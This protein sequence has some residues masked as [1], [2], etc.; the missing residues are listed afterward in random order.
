M[1]QSPA[2]TGVTTRSQTGNYYR[3]VEPDSDITVCLKLETVERLQREALHGVNGLAK[4]RNEVGGILLG[5]VE[6]DEGRTLTFVDDFEAVPCEYRSGASYAL[7][8]EAGAFEAALA[9]HGARPT[10]SVVGYYRSH[11]RE[12][13]YLSADD[14]RLIHRHFRGP[15][16]LFLLIKTLPNRA[17]TAGFFFWKD[18]RIQSEFTDSEAPLIPI[19]LSSAAENGSLGESV[20]DIPVASPRPVLA[21]R[22]AGPKTAAPTPGT[23]RGGLRGL[24]N[25]VA[26]ACATA[27][28][29]FGVLL[30][31]EK[32]PVQ[33]Q[34]PVAP[35]P[36]PVAAA[37]SAAPAPSRVRAPAA[38]VKPPAHRD[39]PARPTSAPAPETPAVRPA[40]AA[41]EP[42]TPPSPK[43][44][45][46][47]T[48]NPLN[49]PPAP[50]APS[51]IPENPVQPVID[52]PQTPAAASVP[53][54]VPVVVPAAAPSASPAA[55]TFVG[56]QV[57]HQVTP[58]VPRGVGPMITT[59]V[60]V[61]VA[62]AIDVNG[63]VSGAR[64]AS[65]KGVAA[66][67]LTIEALKAAQLFR[68]RPAQENGRNVPDTMVLTFRFARTTK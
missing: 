17:C 51:P 38:A 27:A 49:A 26:I 29:T 28:L 23:R 45:A 68:F 36:I 8:D 12:G 24:M 40:V 65:T 66:G 59:D 5:R 21:A 52:A 11:N 42:F 6:F 67:L 57:T 34:T 58:A 30:Y 53:L 19:S 16:N 20:D 18:G 15:A 64:V 60:Q 54:A 2:V 13:L 10:P 33:D 43:P 31:R 4:A 37:K 62:V 47:A 46:A 32:K 63:K 48:E 7:A 22:E 3:W 39:E 9:R 56:A 41:R 14:L 25:D 55:R 35:Q 61:H 1:S 44:L 50:L